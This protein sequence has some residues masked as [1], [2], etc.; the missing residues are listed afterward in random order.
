LYTAV[1]NDLLRRDCEHREKMNKSFTA[2]YNVS[3]LIYYDTLPDPRTAN[4][5]EEQI[6]GGF[7]NKKVA[8]INAMNPDWHDLYQ[9][10]VRD[11]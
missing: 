10:L 2:R 11:W 9:D 1:T 6:K 8:L 7:R 4:A 5:R 3:E